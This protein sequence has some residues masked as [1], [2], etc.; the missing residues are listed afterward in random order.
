MLRLHLYRIA[1]TCA[2][3]ASFIGGGLLFG[4][5]AASGAMHGPALSQKARPT[6][7]AAAS[8]SA[9]QAAA[10]EADDAEPVSRAA[11]IRRSELSWPFFSFGRKR[12]PSW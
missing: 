5:P 9:V 1:L 7:V 11:E 3:M 10:R 8:N 6:P 12:G 4:Q 2:L